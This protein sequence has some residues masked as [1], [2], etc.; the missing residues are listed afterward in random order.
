MGKISHLNMVKNLT[1]LPN[2]ENSV[3]ILWIEELKYFVLN[4]DEKNFLS[5]ITTISFFS[6]FSTRLPITNDD[7]PDEGGNP[8][9]K[10]NIFIIFLSLLFK[11][12]F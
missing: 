2:K 6:K 7:P 11:L 5:V 4:P 8:L 10:A 9:E 12:N 1:P 3:N